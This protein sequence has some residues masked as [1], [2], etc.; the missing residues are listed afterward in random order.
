MKSYYRV[1][2]RKKSA[3]A[4]E[5]FSGGFT[6]TD[7]GITENCRANSQTVG[8]TARHERRSE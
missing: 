3:H 2:L 5:C 1:I 8:E 4:P 7:F 6:G